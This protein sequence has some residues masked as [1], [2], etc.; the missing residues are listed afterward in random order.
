MLLL[1]FSNFHHKSNNFLYQSEKKLNNSSFFV[2]FERFIV[3][4][5][6]SSVALI[7]SK[8]PQLADIYLY[9]SV[10]WFF[11]LNWHNFA[12]K[13]KV[14]FYGK[15]IFSQL[16]EFVDKYEFNKC[17]KR[18]FGNHGV[19]E[20]S[21]WNQ[22]LQLLLA[23]LNFVSDKSHRSLPCKASVFVWK[24]TKSDFTTWAKK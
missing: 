15:Y 6:I 19:R 8:P 14:M 22:F 16:I 20:M 7:F 5:R 18:Y 3:F 11:D 13:S 2:F 23:S 24:Y 12:I 4:L 10:L 9:T 1:R 21:C 17:V